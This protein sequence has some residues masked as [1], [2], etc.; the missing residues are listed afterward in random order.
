MVKEQLSVHQE[1]GEVMECPGNEEE[2]GGVPKTI[3]HN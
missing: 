2:T 1:E 3:S